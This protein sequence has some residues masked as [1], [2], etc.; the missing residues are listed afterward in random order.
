MYRSYRT[1]VR[2]VPD[3]LANPPRAFQRQLVAFRQMPGGGGFTLDTLLLLF[4][5]RRLRFFHTQSR[6]TN[7][8]ERA[9]SIAITS[10]AN[11]KEGLNNIATLSIM[12]GRISVEFL[13]TNSIPRMCIECSSL[14]SGLEAS[15]NPQGVQRESRRL[16]HE[17]GFRLVPQPNRRW[18]GVVLLERSS[19]RNLQLIPAR[20]SQMDG[21]KKPQ[22]DQF[23]GRSAR[24]GALCGPGR[25]MLLSKP[26]RR[27]LPGLR[28]PPTLGSVPAATPGMPAQ[29]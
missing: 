2:Y 16:R 13:D 4:P 23:G 7:R 24:A 18:H 9:S 8:S 3:L 6:T 27:C 22:Y 19:F 26:E 1:R 5:W 25:S 28:E 12:S 11:S 15:S 21:T 29:S 10:A 20:L 14:F 17:R